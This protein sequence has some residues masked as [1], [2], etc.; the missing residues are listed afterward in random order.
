MRWYERWYNRIFP[1]AT[2]PA[3]QA[4][5]V[6]RRLPGGRTS[7]DTDN[8]FLTR[9]W[10]VEPPPDYDSNWRLI[11][12][13]TRYLDRL[14]PTELIDLLADF[15]PEVSKALW[16]FLRL[17]N[18]G[19]E[20]Q[21][22]GDDGETQDERG[23]EA[24]QLFL[25]TL[26]DLYGS[27]D[28]V[29]GKLF[30]GA[31]SRG[32]LCA[33][34]VLDRRGRVPIDFA[35]PDPYSIRHRRKSDPVRGE[36]WQAGQWQGNNFM[37]LDI[38]TFR[39]VPID[40]GFG[41]PYGRPLVMPALF[42]TLFLL[43]MLHDLKRVIQ[44]QGYP[45][46][47]ISI[48][49]ERM[50]TINPAMAS[51]S[52]AFNT[53]ANDI[54]SQVTAALAQLDPD[55]TFVHTDLLTVNRPV[56]TAD[57][58]SLGGIDAVIKML[59]RMAVRA[60]KTM[61]LMLGITETTGDVQ[62]N[63]QFEIFAAGIKSIQHYAETMIGRLLTLGLE[64]QGIQAKVIFTFAEVRASEALRDAQTEAM[65]IANAEAKYKA[66]WVSQ[67]EASEEIT[68]HPADAPEPRLFGFD[69]P[70]MVQGDGDGQEQMDDETDEA[71]NRVLYLNEIRAAR[72]DVATMLERIALNG[73]HP[74]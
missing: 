42:T 2:P 4:A 62:S 10:V 59:E 74:A 67:D 54:V 33:E 52:A 20:F 56:G 21:A 7:R 72:N 64:A 49:T 61:P 34:L 25:D 24:T 51:D 30:F 40:P 73:Y 16:D 12:L 9:N 23:Q 27:T 36:I 14:S 66:G 32:A 3:P 69:N 29:W 11:N 31:F 43:G 57:S 19:W 15:S 35:T 63:R 37:P 46:L 17:C 39:Y 5:N 65:Q 41:A 70:A 55:D 13:D 45:R 50:A 60:L 8:S 58:G 47:D 48:D 1:R 68:G 38:P 18:P 22:V 28:V 53:W 26:A 6:L 71:A 44:Q